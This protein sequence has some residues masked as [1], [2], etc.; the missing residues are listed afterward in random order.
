[1]KTIYSLRLLCFILISTGCNI[2]SE[3]KKI[4]GSWTI[5]KA[6]IQ[7][8]KEQGNYIGKRQKLEDSIINV[9][10]FGTIYNFKDD[11]KITITQNNENFEGTWQMMKDGAGKELSAIEMKGKDWHETWFPSISESLF[12]MKGIDDAISAKVMPVEEGDVPISI[13]LSK[14]K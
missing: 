2:G 10:F 13:E 9:K 11:N 4:I 3:K 8:N 7:R 6:Y 14:N 5:K 1:M 12:Y